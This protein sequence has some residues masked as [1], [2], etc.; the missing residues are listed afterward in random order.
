MPLNAMPC[1]PFHGQGDAG[2]LIMGG[3]WQ[4]AAA[5][6]AAAN[7]AVSASISNKQ[8]E[9]AQQYYQI[10]RNWRNWY[11]QAFVPLE[12]QELDEVMALPK[13]TPY[14]DMAIGRA[15]ALGKF[16][17][18]NKALMV[19]K[20]SSQYEVGARRNALR[21][22]LDETNRVYGAALSQGYRVE[23][24]RV[25][26]KNEYNWKKKEIVANRGRDMVAQSVI[27]GTFAGNIYGSLAR[28]AGQAAGSM[29]NFVGY[30]GSRFATI[31][32]NRLQYQSRE[33]RPIQ[34]QYPETNEGWSNPTPEQAQFHE[35]AHKEYLLK[36]GL[37]G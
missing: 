26:A 20:C 25:D 12:N 34:N 33:S 17:G 31:Y 5:V 21:N 30:A 14:Y 6:L 35:R 2:R 16:I 1:F 15:L 13:E 28:Q 36:N 27:Y 11:N 8:F 29:M 3:L 4:A 9:L 19:V 22:V 18:K 32:P 10:S 7:A 23:R 24:T 37:K